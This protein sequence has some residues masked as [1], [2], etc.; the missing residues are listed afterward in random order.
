[1]STRLAGRPV[2]PF[3][4]AVLDAWSVSPTEPDQAAR[5]RA[6]DFSLCINC[7]ALLVFDGEPLAYRAPTDAEAVEGARNREIA[8][9][10]D[11]LAMLRRLARRH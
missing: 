11:I 7:L 6:G 1:M 3:C 10:I 9:A 4:G 5:P 8:A 2:C